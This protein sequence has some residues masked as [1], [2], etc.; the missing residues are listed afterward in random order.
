MYILYSG[1][2]SR[3][4]L[5]WTGSAIIERRRQYGI[6]IGVVIVYPP[7]VDYQAERR[8]L[9]QIICS[10]QPEQCRRREAKV[11]ELSTMI[12][13]SIKTQTTPHS[14]DGDEG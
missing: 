8:H 12:S 14:T 11:V 2:K 9:N 6:H 10:C 7:D 13:Q 5:V 4:V 3:P 1:E